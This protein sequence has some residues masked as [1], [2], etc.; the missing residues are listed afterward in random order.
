MHYISELPADPL[1]KHLS[2]KYCTLSLC[3]PSYSE[4]VLCRT[5]RIFNE[6][7]GTFHSNVV[8]YLGED[9]FTLYRSTSLIISQMCRRRNTEAKHIPLI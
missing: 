2:Q 1:T 6:M 5:Q 7:L 4:G 9:W 8:C 3:N